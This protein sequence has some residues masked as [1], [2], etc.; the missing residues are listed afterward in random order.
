MACPNDGSAKWCHM[1]SLDNN[2]L[3][4]LQTSENADAEYNNLHSSEA[5]AVKQ[6][7]HWE[8]WK[9]KKHRKCKYHVASSTR[10]DTFNNFC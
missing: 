2:I 1:K 6:E 7:S 3:K 4:V 9:Y 10:F 5:T 8:R